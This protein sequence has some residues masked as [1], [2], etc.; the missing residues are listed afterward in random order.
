MDSIT[1]KNLFCWGLIAEE[2]TSS[3]ESKRTLEKKHT[4][5]LAT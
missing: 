4:T 3:L 2:E 5:V 1:E